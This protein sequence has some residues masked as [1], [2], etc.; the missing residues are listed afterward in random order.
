MSAHLLN[1][2]RAAAV[3]KAHQAGLRLK[4]SR[5]FAV[6]MLLQ[7]AGCIAIAFAY[8]PRAWAGTV[9]SIHP[10]IW[11]A[12]GLGGALALPCTALLLSAPLAAITRYATCIVQVLFSSLLIHLMEGRLETHFHIFG[13]MAFI[14]MYREWR[15]LIAPTLVIAAD[16]ALRSAFWPQ[17]VFGVTYAPW[18]RTLE[19]TAWVLFENGVLVWACVQSSRMKEQIALS[20]A[21]AEE[22]RERIE[23]RVSMRTRELV[24]AQAQLLSE[25]NLFASIV[26]NIPL[27]VYWKDAR[28]VYLGCNPNCAA[29]LGMPATGLLV[30]KA[31]TQLGHPP[32]EVQKE[33][34]S[35]RTVLETGVAIVNQELTRTVGGQCRQM[36]MSKVPLRGDGGAIIGLVGLWLDVTEQ[37]TL[38]SQLTQAQKLESIGQLAAGIAHEIN[39][40]VQ[41]VSDN[42]RF[43]KDQFSAITCVL[44]EYASYLREEH[45]AQAWSNRREAVDR[46]L[47]ELDLP[48]V[49]A[50]IPQAL[51]QSLDGLGRVSAI[52][53]AMKEF[54]HPGA[55]R[56]E[57][58]DINKAIQSTVTVCTNRWKYHADIKFELDPGLPKVP[59]LVAEF[60]HVILNLV[61]NAADAIAEKNAAS[62]GTIAITT[63][64]VGSSAEIRVADTG[65]GIPDSVRHKIFAPF[66]TTKGAGKGTGQG[67]AIS[68]NIIVKK[69]GGS[70]EFETEPGVGTTFIIRLPLA[71]VD[72]ESPRK[73]AA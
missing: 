66:F 6:L 8:S 46:K 40:P 55:A 67:L 45:P 20:A 17:S 13:S 15:L 41:Y 64:V 31:D 68:R 3:F 42:L 37:R 4:V 54:S 2:P 72:V 52:V 44:D 49:R 36:V 30:G 63:R 19:H 29:Q 25:R 53:R 27:S 22:A 58:S 9:S 28:S 21:D 7:W 70:L 14:A 24:E 16:H 1:N 32:D 23:E 39:T 62:K 35:D 10:H 73:E 57:P 71:C 50:E 26:N 12:V 5:I 65:G 60:N 34:D 51:D 59:C 11:A 56:K 33:L 43:L 61:V 18:W 69:L 47:A 38:E 48:F